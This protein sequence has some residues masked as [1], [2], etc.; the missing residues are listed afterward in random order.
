M[1]DYYKDGY[2][3]EE[4]VK[5]YLKAAQ[6]GDADA[7]CC[8]GDCYQYGDGV[9]ENEEE[10]IK[11]YRLAAEQGNEDARACLSDRLEESEVEREVIETEEIVN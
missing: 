8:L 5:W 7:Q 9:E 4:A 6:Q 1:G 3:E 2:C 10:A 11:W